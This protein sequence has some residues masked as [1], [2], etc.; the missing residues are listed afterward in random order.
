MPEEGA[1]TLEVASAGVREAEP[2]DSHHIRFIQVQVSGGETSAVKPSAVP[3]PAEIVLFAT[4]GHLHTAAIEG[5]A[6]GT[7]I[8]TAAAVTR[9]SSMEDTTT[10]TTTTTDIREMIA[11]GFISGLSAPEVRIGGGDIVRVP[12]DLI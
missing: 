10:M 3:P 8:I 9:S 1:F 12:I 11:V 5:G 4:I 6:V 7:G 2:A